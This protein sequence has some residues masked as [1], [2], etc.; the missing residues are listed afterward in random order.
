MRRESSGGLPTYDAWIVPLTMAASI[1]F[2]SVS[3]V[4]FALPPVGVVQFEEGPLR[5]KTV[6]FAIEDP[7]KAAS[8]TALVTLAVNGTFAVDKPIRAVDLLIDGSL[9]ELYDNVTIH[10]DGRITAEDA[11]GFISMVLVFI[12]GRPSLR[13]LLEEDATNISLPVILPEPGFE[14]SGFLQFQAAGIKT[15]HADFSVEISRRKIVDSSTANITVMQSEDTPVERV[16]FYGTALAFLT[17]GLG[18]PS[19]SRSMRELMVKHVTR[20]EQT[21]DGDTLLKN[22]ILFVSIVAVVVALILLGI[23]VTPSEISIV[24]RISLTIGA[25]FLLVFI[26]SFLL[27]IAAGKPN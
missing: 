24:L 18:L 27:T 10:V 23:A 4:L 15:I 25:I 5:I 14:S 6:E 19:A 20:R 12:I 9:L 8:Y 16:G 21:S 22:W 3:L 26:V 7:E 11:E 17:L 13:D 2:L 1:G